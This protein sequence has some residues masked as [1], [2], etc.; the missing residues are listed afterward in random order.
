MPDDEALAMC[1]GNCH[2]MVPVDED[3]PDFEPWC[4]SMACARYADAEARA[5]SYGLI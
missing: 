2:Q 4:G 1:I 3:D 5:D